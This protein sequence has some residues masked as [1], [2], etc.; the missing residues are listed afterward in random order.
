MYAPQSKQQPKENFCA[1]SAVT[2]PKDL[3]HTEYL[4]ANTDTG[5]GL[6][7]GNCL[8]FLRWCISENTLRAYSDRLNV[9]RL[10]EK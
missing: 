8:Y 1:V 3:Q 10:G 6:V 2:K 7:E 4:Q 5:K 9:D